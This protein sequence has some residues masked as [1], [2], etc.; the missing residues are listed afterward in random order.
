MG[1]AETLVVV[2]DVQQ[3]AFDKRTAIAQVNGMELDR[4]RRGIV[5]Y[6]DVEVQF[7]Y[8][9]LRNPVVAARVG[10][11]IRDEPTP[12]TEDWLK[13]LYPELRKVSLFA[14]NRLLRGYRFL[15]GEHWIRPIVEG[16]IFC[17]QTGWLFPGISSPIEMMVGAPGHSIG[18]QAHPLS[19]RFHEQLAGWL[20]AERDVPIWIELMQDARDYLE[21]GRFRHVVIDTRTA[22]E[23]Y[24]DQT[25]LA[26]FKDQGLAPTEAA[27]LLRVSRPRASSVLSLEDAIGI[28]RINDQ[29]E[30]WAQESPRLAAEST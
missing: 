1:G 4:D 13:S 26:C 17:M 12:L 19:S 3:E 2:R 11:Q 30:V 18:L 22:L 25:L 5:R 7:P 29:A 8:D 6:S 27:Y 21:T 15:S 24:L 20:G 10:F 9:V 28:G 14:V 23:L 16:D